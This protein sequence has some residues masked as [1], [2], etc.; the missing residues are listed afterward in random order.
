MVDLQVRELVGPDNNVIGAV[1][2]GVDSSVA[3]VLMHRC[4]KVLSPWR[5]YFDLFLERSV[6]DSMPSWWTMVV[7]ARTSQ[8]R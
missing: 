4:I 1:S 6:V 5:T 2:G 8:Q 3:A 7:F